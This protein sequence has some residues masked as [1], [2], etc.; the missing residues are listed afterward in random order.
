MFGRGLPK[1]PERPGEGGLR[2]ALGKLTVTRACF[3]QDPHVKAGSPGPGARAGKRDLLSEIMQVSTGVWSKDELQLHREVRNTGF[4]HLPPPPFMSASVPRSCLLFST[5]AT[6]PTPP[7][8]PTCM[9]V[10]LQ[11][12]P[13]K[14]RS[15]WGS[16]W[17][18]NYITI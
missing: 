17:G 15:F 13:P 7:Q 1:Y 8:H 10:S 14:F 9:P 6:A 11:S 18:R 5:W 3:H 2:P 4:S 16:F 12:I